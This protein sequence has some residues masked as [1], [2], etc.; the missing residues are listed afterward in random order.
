MLPPGSRYMA[1]ISSAYAWSD[2]YSALMDIKEVATWC[3]MRLNGY[4]DELPE[5][6]SRPWKEERRAK[7]AKQASEKS[8]QV[9]EKLNS[10]NWEAV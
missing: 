9:N 8:K 7:K 1:A 5:I 3:L 6:V 2:E 4:K 10:G